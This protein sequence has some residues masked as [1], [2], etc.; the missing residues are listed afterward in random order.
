MFH[1]E[2]STVPNKH[3]IILFFH[4]MQNMNGDLSEVFETIYADYHRPDEVICLFGQYDE[5]CFK[6]AVLDEQIVLMNAC[7]FGE[8]VPFI[9]VSFD[10]DGKLSLCHC[11]KDDIELDMK[12]L[13]NDIRTKGVQVLAERNKVVEISPPG[14]C[15]VK[16]SSTIDKEF[17]SSHKLGRS[18]QENLFIAFSLL[19]L[20]DAHQRY[21]TIYV[22]TSAINYVVLSLVQLI[23]RFS[24]TNVYSPNYI[25]FHS[26]S[27]LVTHR[28]EVADG[29][30]V[31]I[32]AS[33]RNSLMKK[34]SIEWGIGKENVITLLS[35]KE[36]SKVLCKVDKNSTNDENKREEKF[37]RRVDEYFS[38]EVLSPKPVMLK[39]LHGLRLNKWPFK[40]IHNES[41]LRCNVKK[42]GSDTIKEFMVHLETTELCIKDK[43]THWTDELIQWHVPTSLKWV[44]T[45]V[46]DPWCE[47][48]LD[49]IRKFHHSEIDIIDF[50]DV[51]KKDFEQSKDALLTYAPAVGSGD[52]FVGLNRDL[53]IARHDGM[54][55]FAS[56]FQL[57]KGSQNRERARKSILFGPDF[58]KY[59]LF[60]QYELNIPYRY[61]SSSWEKEKQLLSL[62]ESEA[63][64]WQARMEQLHRTGQGLDGKIGINSRDF[65]GNLTFSRHFAFW[66]FGYKD[67]EV[68]PEAVYF[69]VASVLQEARDNPDFA[70]E[71]SLFSDIYQ[72]SVLSPENFVRFNDPLLQSC[73][74]RAALNSEVD[75]SFDEYFSDQF[76]EILKRLL[77]HHNDEK[78]EASIDLLFGVAVEKIRLTNKACKKLYDCLL[79]VFGD[80]NSEYKPLLDTV[81][82]LL[83]DIKHG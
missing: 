3:S 19:P 39:K 75:Y 28:P 55:V 45:H 61:D 60:I 72:H 67:S 38:T 71:D 31:V 80:D 58:K 44:V 34:I 81:K 82:R 59:R 30:L 32:S 63:P 24:P 74:W 2:L 8:K 29:I 70:K 35:F 66:S 42:Q 73:L 37:I 51:L 64:I 65:N 69:T 1:F 47:L 23:N 25:S 62:W 48:F 77:Y 16:P 40:L 7:R 15:F 18:A 56:S 76:V 46:G 27:G 5:E 52:L 14:T 33:T 21:H 57:Y 50:K 6:T 53:R 10:I 83:N 49:R 26:Y 4:D 54:R 43:L 41:V 20:I 12:V 68:R 78:G 22:D 17:I 9:A 36:E 11:T 13:S 79:E